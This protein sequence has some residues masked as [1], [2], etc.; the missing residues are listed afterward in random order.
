MRRVD[1]REPWSLVE[2]LL[3]SGWERKTIKSGDMSFTTHD[4]NI[5]GI[6]RKTYVDLLNSIGDRFSWQLDEM[7]DF[8]NINIL[9]IEGSL[10]YRSDTGNIITSLGTSRHTRREIMNYLLRWQTKGFLLV[11]TASLNDTVMRLNELYA[12]FQKPYSMSSYSR[13]YT[14]DRVLAAPSGCR[15]KTFNNALQGRSLLELAIMSIPKDE[16]VN[17]VQPAINLPY[18]TEID[19]IGEGRAESIFKHFTRG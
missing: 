18:I 17:I 9:L 2:L 7:L 13:Q 4:N 16:R 11:H 14:D 6:T 8:Y 10:Q 1:T 15:G 12:F 5:V 19:G 3:E